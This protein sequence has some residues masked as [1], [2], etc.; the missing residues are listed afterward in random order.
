MSADAAF[1]IIMGTLVTALL[2]TVFV[3]FCL[4]R[5]ALRMLRRTEAS[6]SRAIQAHR[7]ERREADG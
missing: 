4:I 2:V 3:G 6:T 1:Y 5:S 7:G